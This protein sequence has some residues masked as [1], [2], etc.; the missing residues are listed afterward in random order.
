MASGRPII[1]FRFPGWEDYFVHN[2]DIVI[3]E[4][5]EDIPRKVQWSPD[6]GNMDKNRNH[7]Y[8]GPLVAPVIWGLTLGQE[9]LEIVPHRC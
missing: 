1:S 9:L 3:A 5:I 2:K 6:M 4:K 7:R 8:I